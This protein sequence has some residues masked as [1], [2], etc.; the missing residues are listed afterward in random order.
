MKSLLWWV[1]GWWWV[2]GYVVYSVF[3]VKL[4]TQ[5]EQFKQGTRPNQK[6]TSIQLNSTLN[7]VGFDT[8]MTLHH[9][10]SPTPPHPDWNSTTP[11]EMRKFSVN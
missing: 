5:D 10:H 8:I 3:S 7:A 4:E 2:D 1:G 11:V 6:L 9:H